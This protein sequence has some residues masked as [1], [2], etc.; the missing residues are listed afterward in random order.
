MLFPEREGDKIPFARETE[1][2]LTIL[3]SY[4]MPAPTLDCGNSI[5]VDVNVPLIIDSSP[6]LISSLPFTSPEK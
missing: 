5:G 4:V 2:V 3:P 1:R 6:L